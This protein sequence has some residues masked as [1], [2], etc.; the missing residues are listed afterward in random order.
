M[1][2]KILFGPHSFDVAMAKKDKKDKKENRSYDPLISKTWIT[3]GTRFTADQRLRAKHKWSVSSLAILSLY[4]ITLSSTE[5][6]NLHLF[7]DDSITVQNDD[8]TEYTPLAVLFLSIFILII[9]MI[10]NSKNHLLQAE[11]MHQCALEIQ[12]IY[13]RLQLAIH[14]KRDTYELRQSLLEEY[15]EVLMKYP[16]HEERAYNIFK[17]TN[18]TE[19]DFNF[20]VIRWSWLKMPVAKCLLAWYWVQDFWLYLFFI[21]GPLLTLWY[22][23]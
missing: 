22:A 8:T 17:A 13:H 7:G 5:M 18:Y 16:N 6:L 19:T 12:S 20:W 10:E 14:N 21:L 3:K 15:D 11:K 2:T 4:L 1:L 23:F 9:T